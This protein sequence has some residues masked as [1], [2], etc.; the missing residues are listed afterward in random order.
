MENGTKSAKAPCGALDVEKADCLSRS[1]GQRAVSSERGIWSTGGKS[2][3]DVPD[4]G[5]RP[6]YVAMMPPPSVFA[7][8]AG[9]AV[10]KQTPEDARPDA[11]LTSRELDVYELVQ[12]GYT[13]PQIAEE[14][15]MALGTVHVHLRRIYKKLGVRSRGE[16]A[17]R[18]ESERAGEDPPEKRTARMSTGKPLSKASAADTQTKQRV[19]SA[20]LAGKP[21]VAAEARRLHD[22]V[23]TR[24][25][26]EVLALLVQGHPNFEIARRSNT[27]EATVKNQLHA[28]YRKLG[29]CNR[30]AAA[31]VA[32]RIDSVQQHLR[33]DMES[34]DIRHL[35]LPHMTHRRLTEGSVLVEKGQE[36]PELL[37]VHKGKVAL[38]EL[39]Q[40]A[41]SGDLVGE[42]GVFA[43]ERPSVYTAR[44]LCEVDVFSISADQAKRIYLQSPQFALHIVN[45]VASRLLA[46][47]ENKGGSP[48]T[49]N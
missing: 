22:D 12:R 13:S 47:G 18:S 45:L 43:A 38:E 11:N 3:E 19:A 33:R 32:N 20:L 17:R 29:V 8:G 25:E 30:A 41:E 5:T 46:W 23:L 9:F 7:V 49:A 1:A 4:V 28:I 26:I 34:E 16:I 6:G 40:T 42:V 48:A 27:Q 37:Y 35:L 2:Q 14:L 24:R 31:R 44:C 39:N 10:G 21:E 15:E 36:V